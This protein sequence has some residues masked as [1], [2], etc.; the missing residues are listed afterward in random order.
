MLILKERDVFSLLSNLSVPE[1]RRLLDSL[2]NSL[3][4]YSR[5]KHAPPSERTIHQPERDVIVTKL[6][7]TT[8][9]MPSSVTTSTGVKVVTISPTGGLKGAINLFAPDGTLL[10]VLNAEEVTAFRTSLAVMIPFVRYPHPKTNM[11]VFGAGRQAE[12]HVKLA[13]LLGEGAVKH[14]TVVNRSAPRRMEQLFATLKQKYPDVTLDLLLKTDGEYD[15][16]LQESIKAADII[17]GC[18][19]STVPHFPAS[20]LDHKPRYISLIG[21]YKPEMQEVDAETLLSGEYIYVD[22]EEG[23]LS[24]AGEL[25][26]ANVQEHQLIELGE[27]L[28]DKPFALDGNLVFKCVGLG[29]MDTVMAGELLRMAQEKGVGLVVDDF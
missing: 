7:N 24:E 25:I 6:G 23:C 22:T 8:L 19:P 29:I 15:A 27:L 16:K 11:L 14:V 2:H 4:E 3:R 28:G 1:C 26:K 9:F 5:T 20:Y 13:L 10:G 18:T 17:C 21:S 12:W